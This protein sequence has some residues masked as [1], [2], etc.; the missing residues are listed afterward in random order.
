[1]ET[2]YIKENGKVYR[3][4]THKEEYDVDAQIQAYQSH[5]DTLQTL[6]LDT[7]DKLK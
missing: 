5:L 4:E 6:K 3:L 7:I 1:M 2:T